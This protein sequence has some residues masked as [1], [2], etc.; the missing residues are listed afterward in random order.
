MAMFDYEND[1]KQ[2]KLKNDFLFDNVY[3]TLKRRAFIKHT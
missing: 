3:M 1:I 2:N